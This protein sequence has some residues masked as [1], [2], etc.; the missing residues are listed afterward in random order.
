MYV[1]THTKN[2]K[3]RYQIF[4]IFHKAQLDHT[5]TY[6]GM[7]D[8][9]EFNVKC[10]PNDTSFDIEFEGETLKFTHKTILLK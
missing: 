3:I 5:S 8:N 9:P 4:N 7:S 2:I 10:S 6:C 1:I